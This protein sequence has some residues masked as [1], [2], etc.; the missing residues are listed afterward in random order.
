[1]LRDNNPP[2]VFW[3]QRKGE[4]ERR[5]MFFFNV[6]SSYF[7]LL[8]FFSAAVLGKGTMVA[9]APLRGNGAEEHHVPGTDE[10]DADYD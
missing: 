2:N 5:E 4:D 10:V 7:A 8:I 1:M 3:R 6:S 9:T